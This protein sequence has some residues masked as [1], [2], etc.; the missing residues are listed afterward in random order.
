MILERI[1]E[2]ENTFY[3]FHFDNE[4]CKYVVKRIG[5]K[6]KGVCASAEPL[7]LGEKFFIDNEHR[8]VLK[9]GEVVSLKTTKIIKMYKL[10]TGTN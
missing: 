10:V 8:L 2:T 9:D 3:R 1:I 4:K 6:R 5:S 7:Y